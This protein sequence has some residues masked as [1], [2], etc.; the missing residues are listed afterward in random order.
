[1]HTISIHARLSEYVHTYNFPL[2]IRMFATLPQLSFQDTV[3]Y[4]MDK[5][6]AIPYA[7]TGVG[8]WVQIV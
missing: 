7:S 2:H 5:T 1:M 3:R 6:K 4:L 8:L